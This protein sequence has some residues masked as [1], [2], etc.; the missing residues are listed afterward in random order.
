MIQYIM[1]LST[2]EIETRWFILSLIDESAYCSL[3]RFCTFYPLLSKEDCLEAL[4]CAMR[5]RNKPIAQFIC[6]QQ[7]YYL[8]SAFLYAAQLNDEELLRFFVD[9]DTTN[10][11]HYFDSLVKPCI[12]RLMDQQNVILS[13]YIAKKYNISYDEIYYII[14]QRFSYAK[15]YYSIP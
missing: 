3:D 15:M 14:N 8:Q 9:Y 5:H 6:R 2:I 12:A 1:N 13:V 11:N 10:Q 4:C 7:L